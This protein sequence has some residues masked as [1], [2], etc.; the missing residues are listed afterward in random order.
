M[1]YKIEQ[2][3][4]VS[5]GRMSPGYS[6]IL[7]MR[8]VDGIDNA[9]FIKLFDYKHFHILCGATTRAK[10]YKESVR[11]VVSEIKKLRN[12]SIIKPAESSESKIDIGIEPQAATV[13]KARAKSKV[14]ESMTTITIP[15]RGDLPPL[16]VKIVAPRRKDN[17]IEIEASQTVIE[18]IVSMVHYEIVKRPTDIT[19][20][21]ESAESSDER[22]DDDGDDDESTIV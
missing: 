6:T 11:I 9:S 18:H 8:K 19:L 20:E 16:V 4:I 12:A 17:A 22:I 14:K 1:E 13:K 7:R 2:A 21:S 3:L 5:G 15:A 10:S